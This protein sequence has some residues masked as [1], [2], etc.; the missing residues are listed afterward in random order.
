MNKR[1]IY[2]W[3]GTHKKDMRPILNK[4]GIDFKQAF[5]NNYTYIILMF[6]TKEDIILA[7]LILKEYDKDIIKGY[8][9]K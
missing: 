6:N 8:S 3:H 4:A 1:I 2:K 7:K 5:N 9:S